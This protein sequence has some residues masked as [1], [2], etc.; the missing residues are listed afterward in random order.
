M[1][2]YCS[3]LVAYKQ[4]YQ[5]CTHACQAGLRSDPICSLHIVCF[6]KS[7]YKVERRGWSGNSS[8][9]D[10]AGRREHD[11]GLQDRK[12]MSDVSKDAADIIRMEGWFAIQPPSIEEQDSQHEVLL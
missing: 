11:S 3:K 9:P 8:T 2:Y 10:T 1:L 6:R 7:Q 5:D 4:Q 12:S